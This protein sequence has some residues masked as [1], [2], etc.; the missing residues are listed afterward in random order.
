MKKFITLATVLALAACGGG[1]SGQSSPTPSPTPT[2]TPGPTP[3]PAVTPYSLVFST[4]LDGSSGAGYE[5]VR[6]MAI[7]AQGNIYVTGG[8]TAA[9][10]PT[11]TG[12]YQTTFD[13]SGTSV[14]NLGPSNVFVA[15]ISPSGQLL[16]STFIGGPN[17]DRAYAVRVGTDGSVYVGG[18][19]GP[20]FPT[21]SGVV[22]PA[23]AGDSARNREYGAQDGFVAKL[24]SDGKQLL[25]STYVG[26]SK[27]AFL[28]DID[29]DS[30]GRVYLAAVGVAQPMSA[31]ITSNAWQPSP[32]GDGNDAAYIRLSADAKTVQ[33]GT[34]Y[35]ASNSSSATSTGVASIR[36]AKDGSVVLASVENG[37]DFKTKNAY[38]PN[39]AGGADFILMKFSTADQVV[40]ATYLGGSG[41]E[42]NETHHMALDD[43][44]RIYLSGATRS[45][46]YP[47]TTGVY[48]RQL[49]GRSDTLVSILSANGQQLVASTLLGGNG[50]EMTQGINV[51]HKNG[52]PDAV[53]LSGNTDSTNLAVTSGAPQT[54]NAGGYEAFLAVLS[55]DLKTLRFATYM[56][57][58]GEDDGSA[59]AITPDASRIYFGG[60]TLS[61]A[62][63]TTSG[64]IDRS[65]SGTYAGW[66]AALKAD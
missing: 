42:L 52:S 16:W 61:S 3:S 23:F 5:M 45:S 9:N 10:F 4:L 43:S 6:D 29:V 12:A 24:S 7:D 51:S 27:G 25:W 33:Y 32:T 38:Q 39:N 36:V 54:R 8:T 48:Q 47:V 35:G 50:D 15:K 49:N 2:P 58:A 17:Y 18:R 41:N 13:S 31:F 20:G 65:I 30:Q 55:A 46:N 62:F 44:G 26:D 63:P 37:T 21:T 56:G 11:T 60:Y 59:S 34:Y 19:A 40:F 57:A 1:S 22:Q 64:A 14:G 53:V 66:V 28:R